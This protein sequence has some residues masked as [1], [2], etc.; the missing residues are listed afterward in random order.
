MLT[1]G[2]PGLETT[3]QELTCRVLLE[4]GVITKLAVV[5][6]H[7]KPFY[8]IVQ[9]LQALIKWGETYPKPYKILAKTLEGG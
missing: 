9:V 1:I 2:M 8:I 5:E 3:L 7:L 6:S 4:E